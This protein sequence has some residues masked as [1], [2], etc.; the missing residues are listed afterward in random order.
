M[1][2]SDSANGALLVAQVVEQDRQRQ[3]LRAFTF[4][5]PLEAEFGEALHLVVLGERLAVDRHD[6]PV[7]GAFSFVR[8]IAFTPT[9]S[10]A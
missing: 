10:R 9:R 3:L 4:V 6:Q 8:F 5:G 1:N 2:G 7:D